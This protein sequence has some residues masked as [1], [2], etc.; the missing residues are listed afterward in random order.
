MMFF[1]IAPVVTQA[2]DAIHLEYDSKTQIRVPTPVKIKKAI[3]GQTLLSEDGSIYALTG[4]DLTDTAYK[5]LAELTEGKNCTLYQTRSDKVG[6]VNRLTQILGHMTCGKDDIWIQGTLIAE[7]LARVRTTPENKQ[8]SGAMLKLESAARDKKLGLWAVPTNAVLTPDTAKKYTNGFAIVE[9][10]VYTTAQNKES[11]FLNFTSDWKTD[12]SIGVPAK[13]RRDFSKL[14]IDPMSLKGKKIRVRGWMR[15]Y[16]GP[17]IEL[18][19]AEQLEMISQ[20]CHP[21]PCDN[22]GKD[23]PLDKTDSSPTAQNDTPNKQFMHT[24]GGPTTPTTPKVEKP[25]IE[26]PSIEKD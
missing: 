15:D 10:T 2:D 24:I 18:D 19:H 26:K 25:S 22:G 11:I 4:L 13:L 8:L 20:N 5:R 14:R 7:G 9:G 23:L 1:V 12:F 6:R 3:D 17:Y 16:N 21:E